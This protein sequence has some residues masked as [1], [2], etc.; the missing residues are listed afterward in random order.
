MMACNRMNPHGSIT[1]VLRCEGGWR[2]G[3]MQASMKGNSK[4]GDPYTLSKVRKSSHSI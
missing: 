3:H 1:A 4:V 2:K